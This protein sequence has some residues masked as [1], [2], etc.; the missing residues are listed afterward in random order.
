MAKSLR[1]RREMMTRA[2][3]AG[4]YSAFS[5]MPVQGAYTFMRS[6]SAALGS[7]WR[8]VGGDLRKVDRRENGKT[9]KAATA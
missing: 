7:D 8:A 1:R 2:L 5:L 3:I 9:K 6:D 4:A